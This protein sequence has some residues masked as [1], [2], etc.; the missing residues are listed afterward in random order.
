MWSGRKLPARTSSA[1]WCLDL[2]QRSGSQRPAQRPHL[3]HFDHRDLLVP[4][5]AQ[6]QTTLDRYCCPGAALDPVHQAALSSG[7]AGSRGFGGGDL[8]PVR[9]FAEEGGEN[10]G[11]KRR[12]EPGDGEKRLGTGGLGAKRPAWGARGQGTW[13]KDKGRGTEA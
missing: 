3:Y 10:T 6:T 2:W 12:K 1:S 7:S 11:V 9:I 5:A 13:P 4:M 8:F